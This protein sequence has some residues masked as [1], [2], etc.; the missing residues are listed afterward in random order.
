MNGFGQYDVQQGPQPVTHAPLT[1][2][3]VTRSGVQQKQWEEENNRILRE[4]EKSV[5]SH[6]LLMK[7]YQHMNYAFYLV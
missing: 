3:L 7:S 6:Y 2:H 1:V 5:S 4:Y